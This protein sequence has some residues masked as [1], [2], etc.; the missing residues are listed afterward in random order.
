MF[1]GPQLSTLKL[2][3]LQNVSL[4]CLRF[5]KH[6]FFIFSRCLKKNY[7]DIVKTKKVIAFKYPHYKNVFVDENP[8]TGFSDMKKLQKATQI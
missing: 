2:F 6:A 4:F 1:G 5:M 7:V 8:N 3:F